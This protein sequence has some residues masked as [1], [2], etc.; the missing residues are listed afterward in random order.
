[1]IQGPGRMV[2]DALCYSYMVTLREL[3]HQ[4]MNAS[5]RNLQP[6]CR[7]WEEPHVET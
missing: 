1:M 4:Q 3:R 2:S 7:Y 5:L 6:V